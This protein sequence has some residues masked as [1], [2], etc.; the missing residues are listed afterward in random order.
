M[1]LR[2][3]R[4]SREIFETLT[5]VLY[6]EVRDPMLLKIR[7]TAVQVTK[8]LQIA[9]V[10][11]ELREQSTFTSDHSSITANQ[12]DIQ[13]RLEGCA[14]F[15]RSHLS[16]NIRLRRIPII[17]FYHDQSQERGSHIEKL[18]LSISN[19]AT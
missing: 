16:R 5:K 3:K 17:K 19:S 8:D 6:G 18:L 11:F 1:N 13:H 4:V 9:K 14:S 12:D 15:F 2:Q 7:F 10:Y